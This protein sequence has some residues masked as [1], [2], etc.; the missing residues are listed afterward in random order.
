MEPSNRQLDK[1]PGVEGR[2]RAR[3]RNLGT[4][5][6]LMVFKAIRLAVNT[7]GKR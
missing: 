4:N 2:D 5:S 3:E 7:N 6:L 1:E